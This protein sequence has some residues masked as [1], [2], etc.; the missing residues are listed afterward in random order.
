MKKLNLTSILLVA[1]IA[2][3]ANVLSQKLFIRLDFTEGKQ[4]TL[5]K[6]TK[7]ILRNLD[8]P[9]TITAYFSEKNLPPEMNRIREEF[10]QLLV[11]YRNFSGNLIDYEF[12]DPNQSPEKEQEAL[13]NG[14]R[15]VVISVREKDQSRQQK[16]FLGAVLRMGDKQEV[17][18]VVVTGEG[19]EYALTTLI[20]KMAVTNK[21]S[22]GFIQG[23]GEPTL[24]DQNQVQQALS[25]LYT[26][27]PVNLDD[28]VDLKQFK[29]LVLAAPTD[30]IPAAHLAK[31][32]EYLAGGGNLLVAINRVDGDL[33]AQSC[34][35][36]NTGLESWLESKGILVRPS[37][38][39]DNVSGS[40]TVQQQQGFFIVNTQVPF[41]FLPLVRNF[42]DHP[43][44]KGLEQ[45]LFPF[46]SPVEFKGSQGQFTPLLTSSAKAGEVPA[47]TYFD[48]FN[49]KWTSAD[50][51]KSNITLGALI[52]DLPGGGRMVVFGDGDFQVTGQGAA[53]N[54]D[55]VNL[56]VNA[57]D[58]LSDDTGLVEL[59]TKGIASRP[60][61]DEYL[62]DDAAGKRN[63]IK[64][65]NFGLP[66]LLVIL[67][68]V[69]RHQRR[70]RIREQLMQQRWSQA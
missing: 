35:V 46:V 44:T 61:A 1:A 14:I 41:P 66:I 22:I 59:R 69:M 19:M 10:R 28:E 3:V 2:V 64:L 20:K 39:I 30:S 70:R 50:F 4:Y 15:P 65:L 18:P 27:M 45:V 51:P 68:G 55:N 49:K 42:A 24:Q 12:I 60:I 56:F 67:Y 48:V 63:F 47:P 36:V 40:I 38:V 58:Y 54:P 21:P 11:E 29:T 33:Q 7:D 32:D 52:T 26:V 16:A 13:Q 53:Q 6:A 57:V 17:L 37:F 25:I 62:G 8:K 31:L 34:V 5:S 23:H 9:V 43:I